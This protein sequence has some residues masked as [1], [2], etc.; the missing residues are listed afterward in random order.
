MSN[1]AAGYRDAG[2]LDMALPLFEQTLKVR[3]AKLGPDHPDTLNSMD[4]LAIVYQDAGKLDM[5]LPLY[6]VTLKLRKAKI[7]PDH[8]DTLKSMS[9]LAGAYRLTH[10]PDLALPLFEE[11]LRLR[12]AKQGPD[13]ADTL[14]SMSD[15][16]QSLVQLDRGPEA[17]P[18]IDECLQ[19]AAGRAVDPELLVRTFEHRLRYFGKIKDGAGCRATAEMWDK[20]HRTDADSL[21]NA[22]CY[23]AV[24]AT[25][26]MQEKA[27]I[28]DAT[29]LAN[30]QAERAMTWLKQSVAAGYSNGAHLAKDEDLDVLR[31]RE[32]FKKLLAEVAAK[33]KKSEGK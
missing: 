21:Y 20:L 12:K 1:L 13:H 29:R 31:G 23:R 33:Q 28:A 8:P 24:A 15:L 25:V 32:D 27:S 10:K 14:S 22:A 26:I 30:E 7:G 3:K 11:A 16:A 17:L 9:H 18:I 19:R 2:K 5:A 6:E 4:N